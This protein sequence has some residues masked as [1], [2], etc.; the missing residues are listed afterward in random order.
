M[1]TKLVQK[2]LK[3]AIENRMPD[4]GMLFH[5][6]RGVQYASDDFQRDLADYEIHCSMSRKGN[7]WD[8]AQ[9]CFRNSGLRAKPDKCPARSAGGEL[10]QFFKTRSLRR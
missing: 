5:S 8:N 10:F 3:S 9:S 4:V 2:A 7:C 1:K 6:D